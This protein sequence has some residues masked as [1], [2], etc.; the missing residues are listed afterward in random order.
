RREPELGGDPRRG[1]LRLAVDPEE[2]GVLADD[3]QD[4]ALAAGGDLEVPVRDPAAERLRLDLSPRPDARRN[5]LGLPHPPIL[6]PA[7]RPLLPRGR[8]VVAIYFV[9]AK[10]AMW[11][12]PS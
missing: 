1:V 8:P 3:R 9:N 10:Y 11:S 2:L 5:R 7:G 12:E 6:R 4:E